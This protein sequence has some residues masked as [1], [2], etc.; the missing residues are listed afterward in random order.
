M[1]VVVDFGLLRMED[2]NWT[3]DRNL[4]GKFVKVFM[5]RLEIGRA[6]EPDWPEGIR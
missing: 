6:G 3:N 2:A 5:D 4:V 1:P